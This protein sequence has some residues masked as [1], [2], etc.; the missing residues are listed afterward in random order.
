ME[1]TRVDS[2]MEVAAEIAGKADSI[3]DIL[4][5][6]SVKGQPTAPMCLDNSVEVG[7]AL[8]LI[9]SFKFLLLTGIH[10]ASKDGGA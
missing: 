9:E 7:A 6:Y 5:L 10:T 1:R 4:V 8:L 2:L 3:Q